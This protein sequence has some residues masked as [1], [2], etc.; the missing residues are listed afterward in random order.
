MLPG[1]QKHNEASRHHIRAKKTISEPKSIFLSSLYAAGKVNVFYFSPTKVTSTNSTTVS[2]T[3]GASGTCTRKMSKRTRE[4]LAQHF[5]RCRHLLL[6]VLVVLLRV[7]VSAKP[8]PQQ[9]CKVI[10]L[11]NNQ[12]N[13]R[14]PIDKT[15]RIP[16][17][18]IDVRW[19]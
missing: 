18:I 8:L 19:R 17:I 13:A 12:R 7:G 2:D 3:K 16:T 10:S 1:K 9:V 5:E 4:V 11:R 15:L 14:I 6:A